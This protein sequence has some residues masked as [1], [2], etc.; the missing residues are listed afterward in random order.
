MHYLGKMVHIHT[1]TVYVYIYI[2][3]SIQNILYTYHNV[4]IRSQQ[5]THIT[6]LKE[7][8]ERP[9]LSRF[10]VAKF[11]YDTVVQKMDPLGFGILRFLGFA[12]LRIGDT[13]DDIAPAFP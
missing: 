7:S 8:P 13:V 4:K 3:I 5:S 9:S 6:I 1:D 10:L 12:S 2:Y 11:Q